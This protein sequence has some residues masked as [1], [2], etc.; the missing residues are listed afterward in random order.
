[1][2]RA[3]IKNDRAKV[4][5]LFTIVMLGA[6][7]GNLSQTA[8][9][10]MLADVA[11]EFS[12][13]M[14]MGQWLTTIYM[15]TLGAVVP[16]ATFFARRFS[17]KNLIYI[18]QGFFLAGALLDFVA[19]NFPVLLLGRV[20]QAISTGMLLP[21]VQTIAVTRF[22]KNRRATAMGI[23]GIALG[24]APSIGPTI[25]GALVG[26]M[27]WRSFFV[28]LVVLSGM[29]LVA[30]AVCVNAEKVPPDSMPL[31]SLSFVLSTLG[32]G[33]LLLAFS[34]ASNFSLTDP[35]VWAALVV[36]IVSLVLFVLRQR[37]V[38]DPLINLHIFSSRQFTIGFI[39]QCLLFASFL[40]IT[41]VVPLYVEGLCGKT[42]LE[43]GFVLLPGTIAALVINPLAGV[44]TDR[45]GVRPVVLCSGVFLVLG[46]VGMVFMDAHTSLAQMMLWQGVRN[47]G[48]AG[49]IGPLTSW[50]LA[51]LPQEIVTD[52]SSFCVAVRQVCASLGT[53]TMVFII[54]TTASVAVNPA[55]GYQLAFACSALLA[56]ATLACI[57]WRVR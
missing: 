30:T 29:L 31:D 20:L 8:L 4:Y 56:A 17:L 52:G 54:T 57:F 2:M 44:L 12:I 26:S 6:A 18:A 45:V 46:A 43:A 41:L 19:W 11:L 49:L 24:F 32:F 48:I 40:G 7:L 23:A 3:L 37:R 5:A 15:L 14:S 13:S 38:P 28:I 42:A 21:L 22:Q 34:N 36:G 25:G 1:M 50:S 33:G 55:L 53:A 51:K 39:A 35:V 10:A 16:L 47:V 27:G 9:N